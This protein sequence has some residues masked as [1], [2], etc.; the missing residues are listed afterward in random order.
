M[1]RMDADALC[2]ANKVISVHRRTLSRSVSS[3]FVKATTFPTRT[4]SSL[5]FQQR[6]ALASPHKPSNAPKSQWLHWSAFIRRRL[7][8]GRRFSAT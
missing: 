8:G 2:S 4:A 5:G 3:C 6:S 1:G 7:F